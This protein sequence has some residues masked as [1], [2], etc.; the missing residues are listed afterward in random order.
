VIDLIALLRTAVESGASDIHLEAVRA[1]K[2]INS[3]MASVAYPLLTQSGDLLES[4][5][6]KGGGTADEMASALA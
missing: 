6:A 1:L 4:R 2:E 3:L 5:L